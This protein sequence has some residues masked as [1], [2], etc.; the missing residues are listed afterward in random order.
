MYEH[1]FH[2]FDY[3]FYPCLNTEKELRLLNGN[4]CRRIAVSEEI[5]AALKRKAKE[6]NRSMQEYIECLIAQ[7][8]AAKKES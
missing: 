8:K 6:A 5:H 1:L 7:E 2:H 3:I 4:R